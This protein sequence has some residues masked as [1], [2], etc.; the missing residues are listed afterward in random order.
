VINWFHSSSEREVAQHA[1]FP[2][3]RLPL[4]VMKDGVDVPG[5]KDI[6]AMDA[7][8]AAPSFIIGLEKQ[9]ITYEKTGSH[10]RVSLAT[11]RV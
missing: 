9:I 5:G 3:A 1:A 6:D 2:G 11:L 7:Q 8:S 10:K 4:V